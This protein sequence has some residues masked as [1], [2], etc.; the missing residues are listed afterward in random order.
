MI[1]LSD[2]DVLHKLALCDLL[3]ELL[4]YLQVPPNQVKVLP[5]A[6]F[7]I[8]RLL[9][10]Q[11][12]ALEAFNNFL[13]QAHDIPEVQDLLLLEAIEELDVGERQML[14]YLV[15]EP[16]VTG[17][18]TGDKRALVRM[19]EYAMEI[20]VVGVRL[21]AVAVFSFE[22]ILLGLIEKFRFSHIN[23]KASSAVQFDGLLRL[24]F[25][26]TR[27]EAHALDALNSYLSDLKQGAPFVN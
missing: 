27:N 6:K 16:G 3:N 5:T 1:V 9:S 4:A 25:G 10:T 22:S 8:R 2:N 15:E 18:V 21:S 14:A 12:A 7:V 20:A 11:P 24:A 17:F 13:G 26:P 23:V 19:A